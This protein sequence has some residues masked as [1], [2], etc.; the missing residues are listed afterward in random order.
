[1]GLSEGEVE[2]F[3]EALG[4]VAGAQEGTGA[5]AMVAKVE[6]ATVP[7]MELVGRPEPGEAVLVAIL[8]VRPGSWETVVATAS[9]LRLE[10]EDVGNVRVPYHSKDMPFDAATRPIVLNSKVKGSMVIEST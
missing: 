10:L 2:V 6:M 3:T 9:V 5:V 8:A 4:D 1:M 7:E